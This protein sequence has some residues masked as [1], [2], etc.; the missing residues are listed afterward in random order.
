MDM[1]LG[2]AVVEQRHRRAGCLSTSDYGGQLQRVHRR[3]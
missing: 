2:G 1:V 3:R